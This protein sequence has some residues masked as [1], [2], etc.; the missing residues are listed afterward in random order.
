MVEQ[1][2]ILAKQNG[3]GADFAIACCKT[4]AHVMYADHQEFAAAFARQC[5]E[6]RNAEDEAQREMDELTKP[7]TVP[8]AADVRKSNGAGVLVYKD[9]DNARV[10]DDNAGASVERTPSTR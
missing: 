8:S 10:A 4:E 5:R 1:H 2:V 6:R 3:R 7:A 9:R